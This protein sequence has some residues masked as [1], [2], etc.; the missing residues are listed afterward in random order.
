MNFLYFL[1]KVTIRKK[2]QKDK[3]GKLMPQAFRPRSNLIFRSAIF[4]VFFFLAAL[5]WVLAVLFRS[6]FITRVNVPIEQPTLFSHDLHVKGVGI[7]CRYCHT[8]VEDSAFADLPPTATCMSC[9][10]QLLQN[11]P[12][13]VLI[14]NSF[15]IGAAIDWNR[16]H[17]LAD[18]A[19]FR[20][21][22]HVAKG[23]GCETCH[24]RV[25]LM[26]DTAKT[27][28]L[29]MEWCLECHR[30]PERYIRPVEYVFVMGWEPQEDQEEL[31]RRLVE[32][33]NIAPIRQ[34][35]D[36]SVCHQ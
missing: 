31:G 12:D 24:G 13:L 3:G 9:H 1:I 19:Y 18:F 8:S 32:E 29:Y 20:H 23:F 36:C 14:N 2:G 30:N 5:A 16:V 28:T 35:T 26:E 4:G 17:N 33:Y 22:V 11:H 6:P 7:D 15:R 25:D 34:L 21:D 10:S 27:E